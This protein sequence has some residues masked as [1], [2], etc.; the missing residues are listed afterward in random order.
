L[1]AQPFEAFLMKKERDGFWFEIRHALRQAILKI[2]EV[3]IPNGEP[4]IL[5]DQK[6]YVF[7]TNLNEAFILGLATDITQ[8][9]N[10]TEARIG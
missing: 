5:C 1:A 2:E 3:S 10:K 9:S 7:T 4:T 6:K 8:Y